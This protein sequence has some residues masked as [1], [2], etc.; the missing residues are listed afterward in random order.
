[1]LL[2]LTAVAFA[3]TGAWAFPPQKSDEKKTEEKKSN[4]E[5]ILGTWEL[6][7][8]SSGDLG[9]IVLQLEFTKDGKM[10]M[11]RVEDK[12]KTP[13]YE[14]KYKVE[15]EKEDKL[16]YESITEGVDKKETLTI[17][18]LTDKE[19]TFVD[20]D[21]IVEEFKRVKDEEKKDEKKG[22]KPDQLK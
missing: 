11:N 13:V 8:T 2:S 10:K 15:G 5:M 17:K 16:P 18:K 1:M 22:V 3:A 4:K 21:G 20:D 6:V 19:L 14:A 9:G 7:K 12:Q